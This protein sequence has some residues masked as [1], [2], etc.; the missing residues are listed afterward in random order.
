MGSIIWEQLY[1]LGIRPV[2]EKTNLSLKSF[3]LD[4]TRC[5]FVIKGNPNYIKG[6][7][8]GGYLHPK[9]IPTKKD[10]I[11]IMTLAELKLVDAKKEWN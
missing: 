7:G 9:N 3:A 4:N 1:P 11:Y 10:D 6:Q 8:E 2:S 5:I